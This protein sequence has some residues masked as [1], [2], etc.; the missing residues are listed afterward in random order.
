MKNI[1]KTAIGLFSVLLLLSDPID[2]QMAV[3]TENDKMNNP[4]VI[5]FGL[6]AYRMWDKWPQQ[7]IG[8]RAFMRSTYDRR[9]HN[10][11]ADARHLLFANEETYNVTLDV[12]GKGALYFFLTNHWHGSPWH[13]VLDGKEHMIQETGT[14]DPVNA[15]AN[16]EKSV[17]IPTAPLP[18]PLNFTWATT[19]GA[20]LI[21]TPMPFKESFRIAYSRTRYGT[22]Y[23]IYHLIADEEN[24]SQPIKTWSPDQIPDQDVLDLINKSGSDIAPQKIRKTSGKVRLNK[25]RITLA[26]IKA[27]SSVIRAINLT[28]PLDKAMDL[29]RIRLIATWDGSKYSSIDA[30]LCLFFGAGTLYNREQKEYLVKA[31]P[32]KIRFDYPANKVELGCYFPMPFFKS[33]KIELAGIQPGTAQISYEVRYE[34]LKAPANHNSYFHATYKDFPVPEPGKDLVLLD[35]KGVEGNEEWSGNFVGTS[36]IFSHNAVLTTLEADPRFF[37]DDNQTPNYGTGTEEWGGGGDYWGGLNMTLP[38]AGHPCGARNK[39]LAKDEKDLIE[40]AYRFLLADMMPFGKRAKI[41]L[42]H[43]GENLSVE[44]YE[45]VTY[46]YGLPAPSLIMTDEIDI[47]NLASERS[48]K[49]DSPEGSVVETITSRY[50]WSIDVYPDNKRLIETFPG[51]KDLVGKE[52]YP[53]HMEDGRFTRG[54]S[55]FTVK[56]DPSNKGV[57]LRRTMDY[58]FPNQTAEIFISDDEGKNWK[59][60]G[61]WYTAGSNIYLYSN[62]RGELDLRQLNIQISNRRFRDDEFL[63]PSK[64]TANKSSIRIR[65]KFI[66]NNQELYPRMPY[67]KESAWSELRYQVYSYVMP[68]FSTK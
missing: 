31:F 21:W 5:P 64:L 15:K 33:A 17:F 37:I 47:G 43:G 13:F 25:E 41:Q 50:E 39:E 42:E 63:I 26:D 44:H 7:R 8:V 20:D 24:L 32:V 54:V 46:W 30:P 52:V 45:T 55:E 11:G 51:Y 6:D 61:L 67:P 29:E 40:S 66:P 56:L 53:A 35:T 27:S 2:A 49:Y 38:F 57:I 60:A 9:G 1:I 22:G 65:A 28:I 16:I 48:H 68:Q 10:E 34:S 19:K 18:E 4:P 59:P 62:P 12:K 3:R 36:F 14:A 58:S 23:Y